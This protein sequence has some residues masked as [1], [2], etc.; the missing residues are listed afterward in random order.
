MKEAQVHAEIQE[1]IEDAL[2][3]GQ[4]PVAS[5]IAHAV[6]IKHPCAEFEE[7][8]FF[9]LAAGKYV[10]DAVRHVLSRY[11]VSTND[12]DPQLLLPGF[13]R[14]LKAYLIDRRGEQI[15][16][17]IERM[18]SGE[19]TDKADELDAM[20]VGCQEHARELRRYLADRIVTA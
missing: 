6:L 3:H 1:I 8:E 16:V 11:K 2:T 17:A 10:R 7:A 13:K 20:A 15:V 4:D 5:W 14:L 19:L 9:T 18:T 12:A